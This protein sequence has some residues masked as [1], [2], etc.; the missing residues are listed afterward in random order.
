MPQKTVAKETTVEQALLDSMPALNGNN[1]RPLNAAMVKKLEKRIRYHIKY[2]LGHTLADVTCHKVL[3]AVSLAVRELII[4]GMLKTE[5]RYRRKKTKRVYYLSME[6]LMGRSLENNLYNLGVYSECREALSGLGFD[7]QA[8][9][10][11]EP[12]AALG[13]AGLG[14][15]AACFLDSMAT[16]HLPGFGCGIN[17]EYGL[18]RQ[19]LDNGYQVE[20]PD[21]WLREL[22]P[23]QIERRDE[24][25]IVPINGRIYHELDR[26]GQYNPMWLE[27]KVLIGIP[28][29]MPI[30][31]YGGKTVNY[32]R[33]YTAHSSDEFDMSIFN[34]GDYLKAVEQKMASE[35]ISKVLYPSDSVASGK[36]LRLT[37]EY[38]LV[39]C[40]IRDIFKKFEQEGYKLHQLPEKVAIQLNDTHPALAVAELMRVLI[41]EKDL[42]WQ[43][44]WQLMHETLAYTNHTLMPEALEKW[45]VSLFEK[46]LPRHLQ[47]IFELN[48]RF[49]QQVAKKWPGDAER[50]R[51]MSIVEEGPEKQVRMAHL[52]I[53]GSH[54]VNGV[55]RLHSELVKHKLVPDFYEFWPDKFNNKT[56]GI[57]QRRWLLESNPE[58]AGLLNETIGDAWITDLD[59]IR[60]LENH[61]EDTT[62]LQKL[63]D[64]KRAN[65][66]RLA[67][68]IYEST[69]MRVDPDSMFDIQVKR[70]HE[71]KR[72]LLNVLNIIH[73]YFSIVEDG[74]SLS[75]PKTYIFAG[76]A[77]PGY[78]MAKL[79]IKLIN[80]VARMVNNDPAVNQ[81]MRVVFVPDYRVSLAE[82][83]FPAADLSE[84]IST[85]GKEASGTGNMKF[86]LNGAVTI[87]TLDGANVEIRE[88]VGEENIYI[89][90][91]RAEQALELIQ[92]HT[93]KPWL[94]YQENPRI[95]RV[96]DSIAVNYF[97]RNEQDIFLPLF[98]KVVYT[99]DEFLHLAD[100]QPYID[101]QQ[102]VS[103]DYLD[104][105]A[106][107]QKSLFN[108][109]R[110]GKFSSDRTIREYASDIWHLSP[111]AP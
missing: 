72:Q 71:Y 25:H 79:I 67:E 54:S 63:C 62:F 73:Q 68:T 108:I 69:R 61:A 37:Q 48:H 89:F 47:I 12:D 80:N 9:V 95:K 90:G 40:A 6:F 18:F 26:N 86:A 2:S 16:L 42:K 17:Y 28:Y 103:E 15:L 20:M 84:Q 56:N 87:G 1:K 78:Q 32:L 51:R 109:A 66:V 23:W 43:E 59:A 96:M 91:M 53:I 57:T 50:L 13:N 101:M 77:A 88:E 45:P 70:I 106:W 19:K 38:F 100:L 83:I 98:E 93:Y 102:R 46:V 10:D 29:D 33:L 82:R 22:S 97:S 49:L 44:A 74:M 110:I 36:E 81:Q 8:V 34:Q 41:D 30:V 39:A 111:V 31:G 85:A 24:A 94:Y 27:W 35:T 65:K 105:H 99:V 5:T 64:I 52:S 3:Q 21:N 14:R 104:R 92:S 4:D 60:E 58:L 76:K 107:A 55:A 7:L 75:V 11:Q